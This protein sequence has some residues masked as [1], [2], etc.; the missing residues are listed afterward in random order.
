MDY[1]ALM[2]F[3]KQLLRKKHRF[4]GEISPEA[5]FVAVGDVHGRADLL[6]RLLADLRQR[7][8][9]LFQRQQFA[10]Q[11]AALASLTETRACLKRLTAVAHESLAD[12]MN[13]SLRENR[14]AQASLGG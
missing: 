6:E 1:L 4:S 2:R 7:A 3:L 10:L 14:P 12:L 5:P 8:D 9:T 11:S 13:L